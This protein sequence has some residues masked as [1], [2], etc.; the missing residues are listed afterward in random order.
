MRD[1]ETGF[2]DYFAVD[3]TKYRREAIEQKIAVRSF[4]FIIDFLRN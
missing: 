3:M 4:E 1:N 2:D